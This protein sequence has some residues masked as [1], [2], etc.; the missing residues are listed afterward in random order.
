VPNSG[1]AVGS[2]HERSGCCAD[3]TM[4]RS[5]TRHPLLSSGGVS[6]SA[7]HECRH[8]IE[9]KEC[10]LFELWENSGLPVH[11]TVQKEA[12]WIIPQSEWKR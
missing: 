3:P 12:R 1:Y 7:S 11:T 10:L 9:R 4:T 8:G 2:L 5:Y 6:P